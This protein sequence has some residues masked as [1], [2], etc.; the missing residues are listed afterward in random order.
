MKAIKIIFC[1]LGALLSVAIVFHP[2]LFPHHMGAVLMGGPMVMGVY[3][4]GRNR[5]AFTWIKDVISKI[6]TIFPEARILVNFDYLNSEQLIQNGTNSYSFPLYEKSMQNTMALFPLQKGVKDNNIFIA[7]GARMF[8]DHRVSGTGNVYLQTYP[9]SAVFLA[10]TGAYK[11]LQAFFNGKWT[12]TIDT[13]NY[14]TG[15]STRKFEI[16][17]VTQ[18]TTADNENEMDYN[19]FKPFD[20]YLTLSG[21]A[22]NEITLQIVAPAGWAGA[23]TEGQNVVSF[24]LDGF[25]LQNGEQFMGYF[26]GEKDIDQVAAQ[27]I[28]DKKLLLI[29]G[30]YVRA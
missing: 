15:E 26:T 12:F 1:V 30:K 18:K 2:D 27:M 25:T 10:V 16:I 7:T 17:P 9:S 5:F 29:G 13:T 4:N 8:I 6:N 11:D 3:D 22:D 21:R 14:I 19:K 23:A 28:A 20:P 24:M